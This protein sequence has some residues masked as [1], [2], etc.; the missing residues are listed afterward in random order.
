MTTAKIII[1]CAHCPAEL[2][3]Y[4]EHETLSKTALAGAI[5]HDATN[6]SDWLHH[7]GRF[8]CADCTQAD[9]RYREGRQAEII[10]GL[11]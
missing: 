5:T 7:R 10:G 3:L 9:R 4:Y 8:Y 11:L 2:E 6:S 1:T